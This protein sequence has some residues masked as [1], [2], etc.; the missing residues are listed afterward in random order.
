MGEEALRLIR[1]LS[2]TRSETATSAAT[3]EP[4]ACPTGWCPICQ[5]A[6][7]VRDNPEVIDRVTASAGSLLVAMRDLVEAA[8]KPQ[9]RS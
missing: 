7:F 3:G 2:Q 8:I 4:H 6:G 9:E 1:A 5:V